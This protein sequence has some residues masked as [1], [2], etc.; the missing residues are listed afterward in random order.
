MFERDVGI[1]QPAKSAKVEVVR[2]NASRRDHVLLQVRTPVEA[3][4]SAW[5][6]ALNNLDGRVAAVLKAAATPIREAVAVGLDALAVGDFSA[7]RQVLTDLD[8]NTAVEQDGSC[9]LLLIARYFAATGD[10]D[11]VRAAWPRVKARLAEASSSAPLLRE[12]A[13]T[14]SSIGERADQAELLEAAQHNPIGD[15][16]LDLYARPAWS[17]LRVDARGFAFPENG[18]RA[19]VHDLIGFTPDAS[20]YRVELRPTIPPDWSTLEVDNLRCGDG[21]LGLRYLRAGEKHTYRLIPGLG[22]VPFRVV[23]E[24]RVRGERISSVRLDDRPVNLD[25]RKIGGAWACPVQIDLDADRIITIDT[26]PTGE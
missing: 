10:I 12:L 14:A 24:P 6:L 4:D 25:L 1:D 17:D 18:I 22:P 7:A 13:D 11:R 23:F 16:T 8:H 3:F 26:G 9:Y 21:T 2:S 5:R 15:P 19:V 20:K